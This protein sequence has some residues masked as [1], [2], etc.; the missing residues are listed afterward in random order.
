AKLEKDRRRYANVPLVIVV[1]AR[2]NLHSKVPEI[3]QRLTAGCVAHNLLLGACASGFDAQWLTG[4]VAYDRRVASLLGL[5]DNEY[6]T[7]FIHM[8]TAQ[9]EVPDRDRPALADLLDTWTA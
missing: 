2:V 7:G 9:G 1:I 5:A 3:E 8:G 6:I 4:W